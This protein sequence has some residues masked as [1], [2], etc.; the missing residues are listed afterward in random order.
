MQDG[1]TL[2][3]EQE[4]P[5]GRDVYEVPM[6]AVVTVK[7][8]IN[9]PRYPSVPG[10]LRAKRKPLDELDARATGAA[11]RD[12]QARAPA[13]IGQAGARSSATAPTR[14][15]RWSASSTTWDWCNETMVLVFAERSDDELFRQALAFARGA[16]EGRHA[17]RWRSRIRRLLA[18]RRGHRAG[19]RDPPDARRALVV[20]P[21]TDRGNEVLAHVAAML[22]LPMAANCTSATP[23][24]PLTL[25][26]VRWG[27]SLL[28][29]ARLHGSPALLTVAPHAVAADADDAESRA[30]P[31]RRRRRAYGWR[32]AS[33]PPRA[34]VSLAD[35]EVVVSGGR[36]VGSA[37]GFGSDRGARRAA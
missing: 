25:T 13:R 12:G 1:A 20:A 27:G 9:L 2:R 36:G 34:G 24:E 31:G 29:E 33:R 17:A 3:C 14:P 19:Q 7:E 10:R 35:A 21:G 30:D 11:A 8:G 28:E 26:R 32:S 37:E 22:D 18:G 4:V 5:G 15:P 6:P 23:G 16:G